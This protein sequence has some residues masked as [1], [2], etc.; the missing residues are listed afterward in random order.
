MLNTKI[1]MPRLRQAMA[2][3]AE[4]I[5][6]IKRVLRAPWP[7][8][9]D[10]APTQWEIIKLQARA[11]D[12]CVLRARL[13]GRYHLKIAPRAIRDAGLAWDQEKYHARIADKLAEEFKAA[14]PEPV[15]LA[16]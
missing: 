5:R 12:L 1:D 3:T 13:R 16:G 14:E 9:E 11:T 6:V 2:A 8:G 15:A 10:M 4:A 7:E